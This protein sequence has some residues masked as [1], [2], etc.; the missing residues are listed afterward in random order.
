MF[1]FQSLKEGEIAIFAG[2]G[3]SKDSGLPLA[4]ELKQ[5][6]LSKLITDK[7]DIED[8][9]LSDSP[10]E[11]FVQNLTTDT[12]E[13]I[14][15]IYNYGEPNT[16]HI[17]VAKLAKLGVV[18]N[19]LTTNFD[20]LFEKALKNE[21]L[22]FSTFYNDD[23]FSKV[24][25]QNLEN[26]INVFKI[27][28]SIEKSESLKNTINNVGQGLT[29]YKKNI[30]NYVFSEGPH[31]KV[32]VLGYSCSDKFDINP[33]FQDL[34]NKKK[35]VIF[36][37]HENHDDI[38]STELTKINDNVPFYNFNGCMLQ[39]NTRIFIKNLWKIYEEEIG[40]FVNVKGTLKWETHLKPWSRTIDSGG[41]EA[42]A[43]QMFYSISNFKKSRKYYS[44]GLQISEK[45]KLP[46]ATYVCHMGLGRIYEKLQPINK[47]IFHYNKAFEANNIF[48]TDPKYKSCEKDYKLNKA[49]CYGNLGNIYLNF[50]NDPAQ[51]EIY[52]NLALNIFKKFGRSDK[53]AG[54]LIGMGNLSRKLG[55]FENDFKNLNKSLDMKKSSGDLVGIANCYGSLGKLYY[56]ENK[57]LESI[58]YYKK[59][60][61]YFKDL[62][63]KD[64]IGKGYV[65]I[66]K[67]YSL[68]KQVE[69]ELEYL[70]EAEKCFVQV[71]NPH[72]L[73]LVLEDILSCAF[74]ENDNELRKEYEE[75]I[76]IVNSGKLYSLN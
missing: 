46:Y 43:G 11:K 22:E 28:G 24:K 71:E 68:L 4:N 31:N 6:V 9:M 12:N 66:S 14:F 50:L 62:G 34:K 53:E 1:D 64:E 58:E 52:Y 76:N 67:S 35:Q 33:Y 27:H 61:E 74:R 17:L 45:Q 75:K 72:V 38:R 3:I 10:F 21:R 57:P 26:G 29:P 23:D 65:N 15:K 20:L 47:A 40:N 7:E 42:I 18:K 30:M 51:A 13:K 54:I 32:I 63:M 39:C 59:A 70:I 8:L 41:R 16:N 55:D 73:M 49:A 19:I 37:Q 60:N 25:L 56:S 48:G 44:K 2:A 36:I 5:S 69:A